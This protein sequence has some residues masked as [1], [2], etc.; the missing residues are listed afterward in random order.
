MHTLIRIGSAAMMFAAAGCGQSGISGEYY[1]THI[2]GNR[3]LVTTADVRVVIERPGR[4]GIQSFVCSEASP[5]VAKALST[6]QSLSGKGSGNASG[7]TISAEAN[8]SNATAEALAQLSGRVPGIVALRDGMFAACSA[9]S[10]GAIGADA[11][12]MVLSRYAELLTTLI[13]ADAASG[14]PPPQPTTIQLLPPQAGDSSGQLEDK[15]TTLNLRQ[16][17][18]FASS[19][20]DP[21]AR[22]FA[23]ASVHE[24]VA[25]RQVGLDLVTNKTPIMPNA[26]LGDLTTLA[27]NSVSTAVGGG[28]ESGK[29]ANA[30]ANYAEVILK[31]QENYLKQTPI[32]PLL[33]SCIND[34]DPTRAFLLDSDGHVMHNEILAK[35]CPGF[36]QSIA[37]R[38]TALPG[39]IE[40]GKPSST[41]TRKALLKPPAAASCPPCTESNKKN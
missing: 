5:D 34:A 11:Y 23:Q 2:G 6:A 8:Y 21:L 37:T 32:G 24:N 33:V 26:L 27:D 38:T 28:R 7:P 29:D 41:A 20:T 14:L 1:T 36:I 35:I 19:R 16:A 9:Y 31:M 17:S 40:L 4:N 22:E 12:A 10:N 25:T 3:A 39:P 18:L 30:S 15:K 13:L